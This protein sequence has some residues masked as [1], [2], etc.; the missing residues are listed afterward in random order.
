[1]SFTK[2]QTLQGLIL[3]TY[4][5]IQILR[6]SRAYFDQLVGVEKNEDLLMR[7]FSRSQSRQA[8]DWF[9]SQEI[10]QL[11]SWN[12]LA[13]DFIKR[14][15]YNIEIVPHRYSLER[16]KHKSTKSYRE[17]TY[18]QRKN[19]TRVRPPMTE[20]EIIE[21]LLHIQQPKYYNSMLLIIG[22]KFIEIVKIGENIEDGLK[23]GKIARVAA[24][25]ESLRVV[26]EEDGRCFFHFVC[27]EN[28]IKEA[29]EIRCPKVFAT[30]NLPRS[31]TKSLPIFYVQPNY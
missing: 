19:V 27:I 1:M 31:S 21:V 10:K 25:S 13:K 12:T 9:T 5:F 29:C 28:K 20:K 22:A 11:P 6:F 30:Q 14:F 17:C 15:A 26:E 18:Y 3:K 8:L 4:A 16:I 23:I 7:L 24:L 2:P